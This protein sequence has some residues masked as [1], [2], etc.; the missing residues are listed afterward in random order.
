MAT[1]PHVNS[2]RPLLRRAHLPLLIGAA[3]VLVPACGDDD[4]SDGGA[5]VAVTGPWARQSPAGVTTGA[6]YLQLQ[7][8]DDDELVGVS[9]P[10]EVA[11]DAQIHEMVAAGDAASGAT[12]G[13]T[14]AIGTGDM[15]T[16]DVGTGDTGTGDMS[17]DMGAMVMQEVQ[18]I[19]LPAGR[20]VALEPGGYHV[21]LVDLAAPLLLGDELELTLDFATAPDVT[22]TVP[23]L[24][25]AP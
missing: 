11:G 25:T 22:V 8:S 16:G 2:K 24:E 7:A 20:T 15:G 17:S 3:L 4:D 9:V 6:V 10:A 21:M 19:E 23:V 5:A 13:M 14:G 1:F 12:G 18:S